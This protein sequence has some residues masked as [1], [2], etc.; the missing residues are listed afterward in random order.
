[1]RSRPTMG[2]TISLLGRVGYGW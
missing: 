1:M 2:Q